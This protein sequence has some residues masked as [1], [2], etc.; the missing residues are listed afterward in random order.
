MSEDTAHCGECSFKIPI[1]EGIPILVKDF[2]GIE[3]AIREAVGAGRGQWYEGP[4][5]RQWTGPYRHHLIKRR[6]YVERVLQKYGSENRG[7]PVILDLGCGD[8][9]NLSWLAPLAGD[10]YGSDYNLKRL[11]RAGQLPE[12]KNLFL[13]DLSDYPALDDSFDVI[14][15]NHVLEHIPDDER[16]LAETRRILKPS[17]ILIL[18]VPN[19]GAFFW[20][21][22]YRL[23]PR[24]L[25]LTDHVHFYTA[26]SLSEKCRKIGF[27][28]REVHPIGWGVPHWTLDSIIRGYKWIDDLFE[29][30]GRALLPA[31]ATSLY[32]ILHK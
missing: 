8:G 7:K 21:L 5:A 17:G 20:R 16:A 24:T 11:L 22:A 26:R 13:A 12:K 25:A 6:R 29:L 14:F 2:P 15:F 18:G 27:G 19:E 28:I 4:Q 30:I 3:E 1:V 23:E 32:L 31:Q 9:G 10:L